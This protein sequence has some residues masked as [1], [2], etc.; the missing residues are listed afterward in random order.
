MCI[1]IFCKQNTNFVQLFLFLLMSLGKNAVNVGIHPTAHGL[2]TMTKAVV[3]AVL[4]RRL[5]NNPGGARILSL[6]NRYQSP[7][8]AAILLHQLN[9]L[10]VGTVRQN[11]KGWPEKLIA[12]PK[13]NPRGTY[14][15]AY[16]KVN[17]IL[18][19][20]WMD[21]KQVR[22]VTTLGEEQVGK[23]HRRSGADR[24]EFPCPK[25][26]IHYQK[27][28][29]AVDK[30]DQIRLLGGGFAAK[31][32]FKKWYKKCFMGILDF[33]MLNAYIAWNLT[34]EETGHRRRGGVI[35][36]RQARLLQR[37]H[38]R[39]HEF[40]SI[41]AQEMMEYEDVRI[42]GLAAGYESHH[43]VDKDTTTAVPRDLRD[44]AY[45]AHVPQSNQGTDWAGKRR[46][47]VCAAD[48]NF[49][50]LLGVNVK[51]Y[52]D[53]KREVSTCHR[54]CLS[55]HAGLL[56]ERKRIHRLPEFVGL[57][58][59]EI[60]H[61][62]L[63][64]SIWSTHPTTHKCQVNRSSVAYK[65]L[66]E[67]YGLPREENRKRKGM[68]IAAGLGTGHDDDVTEDEEDEGTTSSSGSYNSSLYGDPTDDGGNNDTN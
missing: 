41:L 13:N 65:N 4:Q 34:V 56:Q 61:S 38:L 2:G 6:D 63:G 29:G 40:Y 5:Q 16:D 48:R 47:S 19:M 21:T 28:M 10:T 20:T 52:A 62:N 39:R 67:H 31:S 60:L 33:M 17:K 3:N 30:G 15:M 35:W 50:G 14:K 68:L 42:H 8:L 12:Q 27:N 57:T 26:I 46:C 7:E 25:A 54:C 9:I 36:K 24:G 51:K 44:D 53:L 58:C 37:R 23:V 32:H 43:Q 59:F 11:G 1:T 22:V 66:R 55:A 49:Q 64:K 18:C 45:G